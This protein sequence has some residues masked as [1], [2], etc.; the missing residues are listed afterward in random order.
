ME[1]NFE[2]L[3]ANEQCIPFVSR[4]DLKYAL[5]S[6]YFDFLSLILNSHSDDEKKRNFILEMRSVVKNV[7]SELSGIS[8]GQIR[9][10]SRRGVVDGKETIYEGHPFTIQRKD[11]SYLLSTYV[12]YKDI[13]CT[14]VGVQEFAIFLRKKTAAKSFDLHYSIENP[15]DTEWSCFDVSLALGG[16][17]PV[18]DAAK[19]VNA[20]SWKTLLNESGY[21]KNPLSGDSFKCVDLIVEG[22]SLSDYEMTYDSVFPVGKGSR[23]FLKTGTL[24]TE[25]LDIKLVLRPGEV[26]NGDIPSLYTMGRSYCTGQERIKK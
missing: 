21:F 3:H 5:D 10:Y 2:G 9:K 8:E 13:H 14:D 26:I 22:H 24:K 16:I 25:A 20:M 23:I 18:A 7:L 17:I 15:T 6:Q 4:Y 11:G 12:R 19:F 1:V